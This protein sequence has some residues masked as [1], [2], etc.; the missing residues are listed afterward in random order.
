MQAGAGKNRILGVWHSR[1]QWKSMTI[2]R[3]LWVCT[4]AS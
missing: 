2:G 1:D 4:A 3:L